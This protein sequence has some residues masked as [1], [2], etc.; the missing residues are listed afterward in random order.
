[1]RTPPPGLRWRA[2]SALLLFG[3]LALG[4]CPEEATRH[5]GAVGSGPGSG[6][7]SGGAQSVGVGTGGSAGQGGSDCL[8]CSAFVAAS[9]F[10]AIPVDTCG[11]D[12]S[13]QTCAVASSCEFV[14]SLD[15]CACGT[16]PAVPGL[17]DVACLFTCT[18]TNVDQPGCQD[19]ITTQ[20]A[21]ESTLCTA[22]PG[23]P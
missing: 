8:S 14:A 15:A 23:T 1:M 20:C 5:T 19:C 21:G 13:S 22:D 4:G 9:G 11:W 3:A 12:G 10:T 18:G 7:G 16:P 17:C 6:I 2:V